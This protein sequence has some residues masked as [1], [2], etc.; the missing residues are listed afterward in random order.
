M[1][2]QTRTKNIPS[3]KPYLVCGILWVIGTMLLPMYKLSSYFLLGIIDIVAYVVMRKV[4][5]FKDVVVQYEEEVPFESLQVQEVIDEGNHYIERLLQANRKI[6]DVEVSKDI[7]GIV[8]ISQNILNRV[9]EHPKKVNEIRKFISYYLPTIAKLLEYYA[10]LESE[11]FVSEN[12]K[13]S[14]AKIEKM[15]V[16]V[17]TAFKEQLDR[18]YDDEALDISSDIKVI[19]SLLASQ[20]FMTGKE[21]Q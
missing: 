1:K 19:E 10:E 18:L 3:A 8:K 20:G 14:K 21:E 4:K 11:T 7:D 15:L 17:E 5:V 6:Q 12:V 16:Q 2:M 9:E 13:T